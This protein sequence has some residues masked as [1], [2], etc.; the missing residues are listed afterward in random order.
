MEIDEQSQKVTAIAM[1]STEVRTTD[2][3]KNC[4]EQEAEKIAAEAMNVDSGDV[5][6][7][8][9]NGQIFVVTARLKS[10]RYKHVC[11]IDKKGFIKV[12][13]SNGV[14]LKTTVE[15]AQDDLKQAWDDA[16]NFSSEVRINPDAYVIVGSRLLDYSGIPELSQVSGLMVAELADQKPDQPIIL[17]LCHNEL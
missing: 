16:S 7:E 2:L 10:Q 11:V 14:V 3:M 4:D 15:K 13:H 12:Q 8:A 1:G 9:T 6:M 5:S 17:V